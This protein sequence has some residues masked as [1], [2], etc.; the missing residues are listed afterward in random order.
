MKHSLICVVPAIALG[1]GGFFAGFM[2][3]EI[4]IKEIKEANTTIES[5]IQ[6]LNQRA[7][8][9]QILHSAR[10]QLEEMRKQTSTPGNIKTIKMLE[11][12]I[13]DLEEVLK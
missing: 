1:I 3:A 2:F 8:N 4:Q 12:L 13:K 9:L 6:D 11:K 7:E 5:Q 10:R